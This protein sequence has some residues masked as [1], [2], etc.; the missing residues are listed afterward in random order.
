MMK[1]KNVERHRISPH[2]SFHQLSSAINCDAN[3]L[4]NKDYQDRLP[5]LVQILQLE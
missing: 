5:I 3:L 4:I 2:F 1:V